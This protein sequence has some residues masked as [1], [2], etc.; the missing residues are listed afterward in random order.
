MET[1]YHQTNQLVQE[2]SNL[3][4]KLENDP[5]GERIEE[6]IQQKINAISA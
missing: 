1:L 5:A 2:A 4:L 6:A 3:F